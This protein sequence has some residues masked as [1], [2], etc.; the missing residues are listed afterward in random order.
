MLHVAAISKRPH[1]VGSAEH[2]AVRDCILRTL[3]ESGLRA[4]I[5]KATAVGQTRSWAASTE[6]IV[7][8]LQGSGSGKSVLL[9]AHYDSVPASFGASDDGAGVAAL[10]ETARVLKSLPR[11]K[12]DI[13]FLF[14]D[15][16][17]LG[18]LGTQ[19]FVAEHPQAENAGVVLN[20]EA[21]GTS[22]PAI[23]F[24]TSKRN[25]AYEGSAGP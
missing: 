6:N 13:V 17:E 21:R 16:E 18:L 20:F 23:L 14:T 24:E 15:G 10:L 11:L 22:G 25:G 3:A 1:P 2:A 8:R 4:E 7:A 9:V 19:A 5:Q 12:R